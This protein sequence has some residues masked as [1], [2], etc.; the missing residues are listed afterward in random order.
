MIEVLSPLTFLMNRTV[1]IYN[2]EK[3]SDGQ[4]KPESLH[5]LQ[6]SMQAGQIIPLHLGDRLTIRS[7]WGMPNRTWGVL[8]DGNADISQQCVLVAQKANHI[9]SWAASK[10]TWT[11]GG[12]R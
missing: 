4:G 10:E 3:M 9:L 5:N 11:A 8:V 12:W 7:S 1:R 6:K 2:I